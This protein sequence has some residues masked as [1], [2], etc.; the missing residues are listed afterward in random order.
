[1]TRPFLK[2][3][4][5]FVIAAILPA[6]ITGCTSPKKDESSIDD[7]YS[8]VSKY[9]EMIE[10]VQTTEQNDEKEPDNKQKFVV[11]IPAECGAE[12]FYGA[13]FLSDEMSKYVTYDVEVAYDCNLKKS[14]KNIEILVGATDRQ[15][16]MEYLKDLRA[17]DFGYAYS[18]GSVVI[19]AHSEALCIEAVNKFVANVVDGSIKLPEIHATLPY[20]ERA[21]YD[22]DA[23]KLCGFSITEYDIV[24]PDKNLMGEKALASILRDMIAESCG[25]S[26]RVISDKQA[27]E[28]TRAICV[29]QSSLTSSGIFPGTATIFVNSDGNIELISDKNAGIYRAIEEFINIIEQSENDG[30]YDVTLSGS[31][32]YSYNGDPL[33]FY[34]V[35]DDFSNGSIAA[36]INAVRGI[37]SSTLSVFDSLSGTVRTN[38]YNNLGRLESA[39]ENSF[40]YYENENFSC[41]LAESK[42]LDGGAEILTLVME[43]TDGKRFVFIGGF[44]GELANDQNLLLALEAECEKYAD[45]PVIVAHE[46]SESLDRSFDGNNANARFCA[47][48]GAKGLY[49]SADRLAVSS[50]LASEI[51]DT[52]IAD[53]LILDFYYS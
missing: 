53:V 10:S 23:M 18:D 47:V 41:V 31:K 29:G 46:L 24:Y 5:I 7:L 19:A 42:L 52:L 11:V 43:R 21:E 22:A 51:T 34:V 49:F 35:R 32:S 30:K 17:E 14:S 39:D 40:Y 28:A 8:A 9:E 27:T 16:S 26:L 1:M 45:I 36:Y 44:A 12:L 20:V 37:R 33:S 4:V 6:A 48:D 3:S 25:Y 50:S 38:L 2:F 13:V 15:E